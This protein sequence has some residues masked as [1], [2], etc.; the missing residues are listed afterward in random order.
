M[1]VD[2]EPSVAAFLGE[3]LEL[4][5]YAVRTLTSSREAWAWL[6]EQPD[7][8]DLLITDQTM[9]DLTGRELIEKVHTRNN[10]LP[11][12]IC[13]GYSEQIDGATV[14]AWGNSIYLEKPIQIDLLLRSIKTLI[15]S[16][17]NEQIDFRPD[18]V[19]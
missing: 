10:S 13:T 2:D 1:I 4:R 16:S 14:D 15:S 3:L 11:V 18:D 12:I 9:P 17:K 6:C 7:A 5:G 19:L 8:I